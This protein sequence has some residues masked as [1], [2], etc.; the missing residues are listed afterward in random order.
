MPVVV[1]GQDDG[2]GAQDPLEPYRGLPSQ[3]RRMP[4]PNVKLTEEQSQH[5]SGP[6]N[7]PQQH[8]N[9]DVRNGTQ[10]TVEQHGGLGRDDGMVPIGA[11]PVVVRAKVKRKPDVLRNVIEERRRKIANEQ[12]HD[13]GGGN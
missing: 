2:Q 9:H 10:K 5:R 3:V 8:R 4:P 6:R 13:G 11:P 1:L 12:G 7:A